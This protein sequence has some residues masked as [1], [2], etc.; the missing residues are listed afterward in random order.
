MN[1]LLLLILMFSGWVFAQPNPAP[2]EVKASKVVIDEQKNLSTYTG[3]ASVVQGVTRLNADK[4]QIFSNQQGVVKVVA[5]GS[6]A[7]RAQYQQNQPNQPSF[8]NA[9]AQK[10]TYLIEEQRLYLR[11]DAYLLQKADFFS[12]DSLDYDIKRHKMSASQSRDGKKRVNFKI[13]L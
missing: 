2:I 12:G 9:T 3:N 10:I 4:I 6:Q 13:K 1:K 11:G 8:V 5:T 7:N